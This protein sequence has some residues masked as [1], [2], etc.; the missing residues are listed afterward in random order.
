MLKFT[1][2]KISFLEISA[3][4]FE[5]GDFLNILRIWWGFGAYFL[6]IFLKKLAVELCM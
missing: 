1:I 6:I 4:A 3:Q 5:A 2:V